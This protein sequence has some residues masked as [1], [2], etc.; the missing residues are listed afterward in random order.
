LG[1]YRDN[2]WL[3]I[4]CLDPFSSEQ[5]LPG[6]KVVLVSRG[7]QGQGEFPHADPYG[8]LTLMFFGRLGCEMDHPGA[9]GGQDAGCI[10]HNGLGC[11]YCAGAI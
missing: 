3:V 5:P 9:L 10:A 7:N 8:S 6:D 2:R 4:L 1:R 11:N